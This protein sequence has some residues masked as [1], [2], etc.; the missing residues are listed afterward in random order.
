MLFCG[1]IHRQMLYASFSSRLYLLSSSVYAI[2]APQLL[3]AYY[4]LSYIA[5][6]DSRRECTET[7][8]MWQQFF[9]CSLSNLWDRVVRQHERFISCALFVM[10]YLKPHRKFIKCHW[11]DIKHIRVSGLSKYSSEIFRSSFN[12]VQC[13]GGRTRNRNHCILH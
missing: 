10:E 6:Q 8:N 12:S 2:V 1:S 5:M 4:C 3:M 11:R 13:H 9:L 7:G